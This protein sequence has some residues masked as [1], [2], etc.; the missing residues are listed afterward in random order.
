MKVDSLK[1]A[2]RVPAW[3]IEVLDNKQ[4]DAV[5]EPNAHDNNDSCIHKVQ[6]HFFSLLIFNVLV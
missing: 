2:T 5:H 3:R 1:I 4:H 6:P